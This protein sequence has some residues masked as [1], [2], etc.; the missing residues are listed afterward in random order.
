GRDGKG[1][2]AVIEPKYT[3]INHLTPDGKL[4]AQWSAHGTNTGELAFPRTVMVNSHGDI[5]VSEYGL[6]ERVQQFTAEGKKLIRVLGKGGTGDGEFNRAEGL[7]VDAQDRLY[8]ADSCNHRVQ[9][10]APDGRFFRS[11]GRA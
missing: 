7:G 4:V 3:R 8:V 10:F 2:R 11:Y 5:F 6:T 9:I 1:A